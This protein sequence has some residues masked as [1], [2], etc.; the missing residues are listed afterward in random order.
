MVLSF[1]GLALWVWML[2][3]AIQ[4]EESSYKSRDEKVL[5][6]LIILLGGWIGALVYYIVYYRDQGMSSGK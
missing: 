6:I 1:L 5:W 4:R 3:D 2:V